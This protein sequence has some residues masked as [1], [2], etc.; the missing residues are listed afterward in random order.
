[1]PQEAF[2]AVLRL[3]REQR[4]TVTVLVLSGYHLKLGRNIMP[5]ARHLGHTNR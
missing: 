1:M 3:N 2:V 5:R 4:R